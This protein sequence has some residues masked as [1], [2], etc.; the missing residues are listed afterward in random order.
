MS[1]LISSRKVRADAPHAHALAALL[2]FYR[3]YQVLRAGRARVGPRTYS[4]EP[5]DGDCVEAAMDR[6]TEILK[7]EQIV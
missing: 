7:K 5:I 6:A 4:I 1:A 3:Q 2:R